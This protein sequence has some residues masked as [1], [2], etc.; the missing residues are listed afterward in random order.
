MDQN[1]NVRL[2]TIKLRE[3]HRQN[4]FWQMT[5]IYFLIHLQNE[6]KNKNKWDQIKSVCIAKETIY[7]MERQPTE[8]EKTFT[9]WLT[10]D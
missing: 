7:K 1:L 10:R 5:A 2:D 3:K 8:W 9:K 6:N 4:T